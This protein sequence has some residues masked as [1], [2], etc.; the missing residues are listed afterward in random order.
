MNHSYEYR[1]CT[2]PADFLLPSDS[3]TIEKPYYNMK[4]LSLFTVLLKPRKQGRIHGCQAERVGGVGDQ[5][6]Q[7]LIDWIRTNR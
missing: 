3:P 4:A 7:S 2:L 5:I 1:E 6:K